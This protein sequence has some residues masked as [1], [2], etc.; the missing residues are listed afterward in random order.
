M[1]SNGG[2]AEREGSNFEG[3]SR[4]D[5]RIAPYRRPCMTSTEFLKFLAEND[6]HFVLDRGAPTHRFKHEHVWVAT[7]DGRYV[8]ERHSSDLSCP[9]ELPR[10]TLDHYLK[11]SFV[12]ADGQEDPGGRT[13]YRLT[14]DGMRRGLARDGEQV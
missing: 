1:L 8:E 14:R 11:A 13:I 5:R 12:F 7:G 3:G 6:Y 9:V 10:A 2:R 4:N